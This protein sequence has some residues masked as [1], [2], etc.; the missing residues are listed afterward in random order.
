MVSSNTLVVCIYIVCDCEWTRE[1]EKERIQGMRKTFELYCIGYIHRIHLY[2][3][4]CVSRL[5]SCKSDDETI[6][7]EI[8]F[9]DEVQKFVS[10][11]P[12]PVIWSFTFLHTTSIRSAPNNVEYNTVSLSNLCNRTLERK[13]MIAA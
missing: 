13:S 4:L 1:R 11:S 12:F 9:Y 10:K 6:Y 5:D 8:Y 7:N 2:T 3:C